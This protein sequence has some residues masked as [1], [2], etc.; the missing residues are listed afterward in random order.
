MA[1]TESTTT[2]NLTLLKPEVQSPVEGEGT[3]R[4]G[5]L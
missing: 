4:E 1:K 2:W 3:Q 5:T